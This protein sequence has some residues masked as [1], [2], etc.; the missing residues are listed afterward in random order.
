MRP[1]RIVPTLRV[2]P[3]PASR[4][5]DDEPRE[6]DPTATRVQPAGPDRF[7]VQDAAGGARRALVGPDRPAGPAGPRTIEVVVDGW[8]F[9]LEVE[10]GARARLRERGTRRPVIGTGSGPFEIRAIIPGRVATVG[11]APGDR[12][13]AGQVLLVVEAMKMQNELRA[14][15]DGRVTRVAVGAGETIDL[16]DLLVVLS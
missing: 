5:P 11:V 2:V 7:V 16:G 9:E 8:R 12:V 4:L 13:A 14:P 15:R 3:A 10:D 6:L 1:P